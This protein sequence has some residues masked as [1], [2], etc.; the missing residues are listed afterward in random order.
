MKPLVFEAPCT[1][2]IA[3]LPILSKTFALDDVAEAAYQV[4]HNMHVGKL[5][6][7]VLAPEDGLGV[8]DP[9]LRA[10]VGEENLTRFKG[11]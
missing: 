9:G 3:R 10:H 1:S 11:V 7:R 2:A 8:T 6:I 4:H 5:G